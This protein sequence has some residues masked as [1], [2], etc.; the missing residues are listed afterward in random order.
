MKFIKGFI[1]TVFFASFL[2]SCSKTEKITYNQE[3]DFL[4]EEISPTFIPRDSKI[5]IRFTKETLCTPEDAMSFSPEQKGT[6]SVSEDKKTFT[7]T[8]QKFY[9]QN[10]EFSLVADCNKLFGGTEKGKYVHPFVADK[11]W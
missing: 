10:S 9:K 3:N 2:F 4:I 5:K 8:P 1:F 7:F 6:W 11:G